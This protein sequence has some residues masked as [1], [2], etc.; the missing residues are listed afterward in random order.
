MRPWPTQP[1]DDSYD[2]YAEEAERGAEGPA[3]GEGLIYAAARDI[4]AEMHAQQ[5]IERQ[6]ED[7]ARSNADLEEFAYAA[8]HDLQAPL[9]AITHLAK[10]IQDDMPADMPAAVSRNL[11]GR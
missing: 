6:A 11:T 1:V 2:G 4:T 10:W 7:L 8:S 3:D 5:L 9:R